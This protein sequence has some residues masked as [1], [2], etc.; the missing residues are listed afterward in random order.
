M[1]VRFV[2]LNVLFTRSIEQWTKLIMCLVLYLNLDIRLSAFDNTRMIIPQYLDLTKKS[3]RRDAHNVAVIDKSLSAQQPSWELIVLPS[4][5]L[6]S[7]DTYFNVSP[8][9]HMYVL[10]VKI[11]YQARFCLQIS[12][13]A[14]LFKI[15]SGIFK[16]WEFLSFT[17]FCRKQAKLSYWQYSCWM[18][19][20]TLFCPAHNETPIF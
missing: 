12:Y 19:V 5:C 20:F 11:S 2:K 10:F 17:S 4:T 7:L 6:W 13:S 16:S 9:Y 18:H 1:H 15:A 8:F 3:I 14:I